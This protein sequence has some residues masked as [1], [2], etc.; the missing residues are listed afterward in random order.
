MATFK[1]FEEI[2]SWQ[3]AREFCKLIQKFITRESFNRDYKLKEQI[4]G[5]SG[6]I[7]DNIAE[8]F[9][10]GG[11]KEFINFLRYSKGSAGESQSQLYRALDKKHISQ[12]EFNYAFAMLDHINSK[13]QNLINY[14][15]ESEYVG[16]NYKIKNDKPKKV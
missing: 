8:G 7:M 11:N 4:N 2:K 14:L 1:T 15:L 5:S 6:S 3:L 16:H 10:R 12:E 9:C 13:T